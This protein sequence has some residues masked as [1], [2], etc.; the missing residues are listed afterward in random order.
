M[1]SRFRALLLPVL[2]ILPLRAQAGLLVPTSSGRPDP[3][4]LSLREMTVD[5]AIAR[6]YARVNV[7]Q[8][9]ENHT[10]AV[11][12]GTYRFALPA[13]A[14]VGDFAVWDGLVRIPG[15]ILE[16]KRARSIYQELTRQRIDPGLLQQGE[17][18][19]R[20]A[21]EG[22]PASRPSGASLFSVTVAPIPP[23]ATKR[24]EI[25]FQ[26]EVPLIGGRG[27]FRLVLRPPD[28]EPT[29]A[30]TF[31]V[32][33]KLEDG[34]F[35]AMPSGLPLTA[36]AEG[37]GFTGTH[38]R[39]DKDLALRFRP[40][41]SEPLRLTAFRNPEGALPEGLALAPWERPSEIP[42]EKD[43]FFLLEALPGG[44]AAPAETPA[45]AP[46]G[47]SLAILFDT[48][49]GHRWGGLELAYGHLVRVLRSLG[50]EDRFALIPFDHTPGAGALQPVTPQA[51]EAQLTQLRNRPLGPG[52][53]LA[54]ALAAA[55]KALGDHGRILLLTSGQGLLR[56]KALKAAAG[57]VPL[58]TAV[59]VGEAGE[60]LAAAS[61]QVLSPTATEIE[62]DLFFRQVLGPGT[63]A[64]ARRAAGDVPFTAAGGEPKLRDIY[65][66]LVQPLAAGSLSGW[67]GRYGAPAEKVRFEWASP[68]FPGGRASL[69]AA[70]PAKALEAR[71]LPR[72]WARAR[73]DD[74]LRRIEAEGERREWVDE[75]I[76]LSK[77]YKFITP[78]TA[79]LAAPRSLLRPRRIQPGDPVLR[80]ECDPGTQS[81][82]ALFPFG[83]R[84]DLVR[85]PGGNVWEGR[86]LVPEGLK[87]GRHP[88]RIL[89]RD[90]SGAR[91]SETKHFVLDGKA[92]D[93]HPAL[94]A[95]CRPGEA[96]RIAAAA[97]DDV[98]FLSAR[99]GD[100]PPIPLRWDPAERR[101]VG[102]TTVPYGVQGP[103]EVVF[104]AV[105]AAKNRGFARATLE[106]RP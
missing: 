75:I 11:Q 36:T 49:L 93:I 88:V 16:K 55:R 58:F 51:I 78:Y 101:C 73:V 2:A 6:G 7:R 65:P 9:F 33:V 1:L 69:D 39:L 41:A 12:E 68:L 87:D 26:Q 67:I 24:L 40:R 89:M 82:T 5:M 56:S 37:A 86:F 63:A 62:G 23:M 57:P 20:E 34:A 95:S 15:V 52:A 50:R 83:L 46:G 80:V 59:T 27:E 19:D 54:L 32:R 30:E 103:V 100:A 90:A 84:L 29:V 77:R 60:A 21:G 47:Q 17:E 97:D 48:S 99:V 79:F 31:T 10:A 105:D 44:G 22:A 81:A 85:R 104:E 13:S 28:A 43:G 92:P 70:L 71:D 91:I 35:E 72:R 25:Q 96:V 3:K 53:D 18:E 38:V 74:L 14:A 102:L 66:V 106:V 45:A 76:A 8:V 61:A 4:V 98:V 42:P 64:K 94:P